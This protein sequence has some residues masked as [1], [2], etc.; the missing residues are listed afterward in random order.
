MHG[1]G[2]AYAG[3]KAG[4]ENSKLVLLF[5]AL[6]ARFNLKRTEQ[7]IVLPV[8]PVSLVSQW[9][10]DTRGL[11]PDRG[12]RGIR[13]QK[14]SSSNQIN[15]SRTFIERLKVL[16]SKA[17]GMQ[18]WHEESRSCILRTPRTQDLELPF[19]FGKESKATLEG[20]QRENE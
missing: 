1:H 12:R 19:S 14:T 17:W 3:T 13:G 4:V 2:N 16:A 10:E 11:E 6:N 9:I 15:I 7:A 8:A 18:N 5:L 20:A